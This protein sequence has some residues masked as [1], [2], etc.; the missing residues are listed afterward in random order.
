MASVAHAQTTE[1]SPPTVKLERIDDGLWLSAQMQFELPS[2]VE[3]ALYKGIPIY[4]A[5]EVDVFRERW[6]WTN[7]KL[8]SAKRLLRLAYHPMTRRWRINITVGD[9]LDAGQGLALNQNFD[10]LAEAMGSIRRISHWRI[11]DIAD[12]DPAAKQT[13]EFRFRLD[14]TQL[15]RPLQIGMLGQSDWQIVLT[16]SQP[17]TLEPSK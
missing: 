11:A 16:A 14:I 1:S 13:L 4:F 7:R 3:D 2:V 8:G 17:V 9:A 6:Y 15:P 12:I 5:A 10:S